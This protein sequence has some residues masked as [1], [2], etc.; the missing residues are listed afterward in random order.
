MKILVISPHP[1][2][3]TLGAGGTLL[4]HKAK[5]DAIYWLNITNIKEIYGYEPKVVKKRQE[6]IEKVIK[7]YKFDGFF[8]LALKPASLSD[9]DIMI[10][11]NKISDIIEKIKPSILYVPFYK[12][13]HSDHRI[14]F[15]AL[16]PFFKSF[17]YPYIKKILMMEIISETDHQFIGNFKPN[18][19]VD[20]SYYLDKKLEILS[21]YNSEIGEHPFP[22]SIESV[23]SLAIYR[24]SQCNCK[25]AE[26]FIL[27]KEIL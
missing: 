19:F 23:K 18:V 24:G 27:L 22:R 15:K 2:D 14:T 16:Q 20:I 9:A 26:S 25:Y 7:H 10:I 17:R 1:D 4:K 8:D 11:I 12:D 5:G 13:A 21:I 6:E 3:E